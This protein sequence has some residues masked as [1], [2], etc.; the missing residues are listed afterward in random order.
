MDR[1]VLLFKHILITFVTK[2]WTNPIAQKYLVSPALGTSHI[3]ILRSSA[4]SDRRDIFLDP[5]D[6]FSCNQSYELG[7]IILQSPHVVVRGN[8]SD[9]SCQNSSHWRK[10]IS[11]QLK[12]NWLIS[13]IS[14]SSVC[15]CD[16]YVHLRQFT[17][18]WN[19]IFIYRNIH[20][21]LSFKSSPL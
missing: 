19:V 12:M 16:S 10:D 17:I 2:F 14:Q 15:P 13:Q 11:G 18:Y 6:L 8:K 21:F 5:P 7:W 4:V 9:T 1:K 20:L 3:M